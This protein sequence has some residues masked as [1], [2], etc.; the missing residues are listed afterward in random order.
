M[1]EKKFE[2]HAVEGTPFYIVEQEKFCV[3]MGRYKVSNE[4]E[5]MEEAKKY[6][7]KKP[8]DLLTKVIGIMIENINEIKTK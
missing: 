6:I 3:V 2:L 8:W 1:E 4:F 5:T 7:K